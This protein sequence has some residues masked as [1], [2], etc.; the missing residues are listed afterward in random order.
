[1]TT[2][3]ATYK[4]SSIGSAAVDD[5]PKGKTQHAKGSQDSYKACSGDAYESLINGQ[6]KAEALNGGVLSEM[7]EAS[8]E[9]SE[10]RTDYH[11]QIQALLGNLLIG[12]A[13][14]RPAQ[15][16]R[17]DV[18]HVPDL[19]KEILRGTTLHE[20]MEPIVERY[21]ALEKV[22]IVMYDNLKISLH[23]RNMASMTA[24]EI[25]SL[26]QYKEKLVE[27]L[28]ECRDQLKLSRRY[29]QEQKAEEAKNSSL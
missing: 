25:R 3:N 18:P 24:S 19:E 29:L 26:N 8:R 13:R 20:H 6:F 2:T 17:G 10:V 1:M 7:A 28:R 21:A 11:S 5:L 22:L 4:V 23:P 9:D 12:E 15:D 16:T 14:S 27:S